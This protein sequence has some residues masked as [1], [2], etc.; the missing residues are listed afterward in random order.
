MIGPNSLGRNELLQD[1]EPLVPT[2]LTSHEADLAEVAD[3]WESLPPE[4]KAE[5]LR[6]IRQS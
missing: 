4:V 2:L 1:H 3:R 5:V 6:L